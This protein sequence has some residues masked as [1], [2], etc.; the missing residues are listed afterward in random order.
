LR[1]WKWSN[2]DSLLLGIY[3][4]DALLVGYVV[5][6]G[7]L[8]SVTCRVDSQG[9]LGDGADAL[10]LLCR[11]YWEKLTVASNWYK[12]LIRAGEREGALDVDLDLSAASLS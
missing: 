4:S 1:N 12:A 2:S 6:A 5:K 9:H 11:Y 3:C 7:R 8:R 10:S